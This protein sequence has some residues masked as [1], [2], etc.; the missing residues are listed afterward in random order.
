MSCTDNS[1][2]CS[3]KLASID[4]RLDSMQKSQEAM[5]KSQEAMQK[6]QEA[7]QKTLETGQANLMKQLLMLNHHHNPSLGDIRR[8]LEI[9]LDNR[10]AQDGGYC[11]TMDAARQ[12]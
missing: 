8:A 7:M 4:A 12:T 10:V 11:R 9:D 5:Q 3:V 6:S 1:C 2:G